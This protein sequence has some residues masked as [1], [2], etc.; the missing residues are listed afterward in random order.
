MTE[1]DRLIAKYSIIS[2]QIDQHELRVI[3]QNLNESLKVD[4][5][6]VEF[7]CYI[8]T[9]SLFIKRL[10]NV[11]QD[12]RQ[13]HVYDSFQGLPTKSDKDESPAGEQFKEGELKATKQQFIEQF[14]KAN[15]GIPI[16]HKKW[17]EDITT[18]EIPDKIAFAFLDGD[19]Y[20][21]IKK[22]L[23]LVWPKL[24]NGSIVVIDDYVSESLPGTKKAVDEWLT[25]NPAK[26]NIDSSLAVLKIKE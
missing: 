13:F 17:F 25:E 9:T 20:S 1:I 26:I 11:N 22:S 6:I 2:D 5:A 7:G 4:G 19:Y 18:D 24:T 15:L 10:L 21:S 14:K 3:L 12:S 23:K 16:I 8:G